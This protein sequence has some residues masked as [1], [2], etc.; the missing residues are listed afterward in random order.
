[1]TL[2]YNWYNLFCIQMQLIILK[3]NIQ[4]LYYKIKILLYTNLYFLCSFVICFFF[5]FTKS[6]ANLL[7]KS[8]LYYFCESY[9]VQRSQ[10]LS[11]WSE[12]VLIHLINIEYTVWYGKRSQSNPTKCLFSDTCNNCSI[13]AVLEKLHYRIF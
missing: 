12:Q 4:K 3:L 5:T 6:Y 1:M 10:M 8:L 11:D 13:I 2:I 7:Y 9:I